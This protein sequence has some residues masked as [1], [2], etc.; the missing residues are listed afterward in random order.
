MGLASNFKR[1]LLLR[2]SEHI[3]AHPTL[4]VDT[5]RVH[6]AKMMQA[7]LKALLQISFTINCSGQA[8]YALAV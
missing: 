1:E 4:Y 7:G 6:I 3:R 5:A 2:L 8:P